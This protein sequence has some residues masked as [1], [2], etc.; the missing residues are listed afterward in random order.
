M[1][2]VHG[3]AKLGTRIATLVSNAI[4]YTHDRLHSAKHKLAM[5]VF[6]SIS[7]VVSEEVHRTLGPVLSDVHDRY[8]PEGALKPLLKFMSTEHGQLQAFAGASA[9]SQ[10]LLWPISS[11]INNELAPVVY[12]GVSSNPHSIPDPQSIAQM[13]ARG[14]I[15]DP[16]YADGMAKNGFNG[17]WADAMKQLN[18]QYPDAGTLLDLVRRNIIA[19]DTFIEWSIKSGVPATVAELLLKTVNVPISPADA[20]LALLRGNLTDAEARKIA[21]EAGLSDED[22]N[23]LVNNTGEPLGLEQLLE[24][25]RRGFIDDARLVK[26][27]LQSRVRNEWV[28][29]AEKLAYAPITTADA[30]T[31]NVQ[32]HISEDQGRSVANQNGLEPGWF[33]ILVATAGEP[34]S[35]TEMEELFNRGLVTEQQVKQAL[36]ESRLKNKYT[37]LAFALHSK[38]LPI[39]NLSEAVEFGSLTLAQGVAE[40]M[41]QGYSEADA[42]ALIHAASARKLQSYRHSAVSAIET[43]YVDNVISEDDALSQVMSMGLDEAEAKAVLAG[44]EYKRDARMVASAMSA[45]R[46]KFVAR[47]IDQPTASGLLD[48]LGI[49]ADHRDQQLALWSIERQANVRLLTPAQVIKANKLGFMDD[50]QTLG[51]LGNLGYSA[52]DASLLM[53][54]A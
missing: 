22:F 3:G 46:T 48:G 11:L 13:G 54:G 49:P 7:D 35:R 37:D 40:A 53:K 17:S 25:K 50:A 18:M 51:Y 36:L 5:A 9:I 47:H 39:R 45:I 27:I 14:L 52:N 34:L 19:A 2:Q 29:V 4:I 33:D 43:L 24:A 31:A 30:V 6:S 15:N 12:E 1:A 23:T 32:G 20:A 21:H 38:L 8:D 28:D 42:T 26:G 41:K 10:G 16:S 44:A